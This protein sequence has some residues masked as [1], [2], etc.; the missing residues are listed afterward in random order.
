MNGSLV[1][2]LVIAGVMAA[3]LG[4]ALFLMS[5]AGTKA[6][7]RADA[8]RAEVEQLGEKWVIPFRG[9]VYQGGGRQGAHSRGHGVLGLTDRRVLFLPIA[10]ELVSLPRARV[11]GARVEDRLRDAAASH[12]HR[13]VLA[14]DD[15]TELG[16]LVDN[17]QAW[18]D[19]IA[20]M[21]EPA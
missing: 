9:A 15:Q 5:R 7:R 20:R 17:E 16:F 13:L 21:R 11:I 2:V 10:G 6:E 18:K 19:A 14:L 4:V 8:L 1:S 12:R 3:T